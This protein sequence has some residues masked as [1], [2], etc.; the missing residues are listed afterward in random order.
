MP[1]RSSDWNISKAC[2]LVRDMA[3]YTSILTEHRTLRQIRAMIQSCGDACSVL[4]AGGRRRSKQRLYGLTGILEDFFQRK[5]W[6]NVSMP[7]TT[8][9]PIRMLRSHL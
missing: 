5:Y 3:G 6:I 4:A 2:C 1:I 8:A 9:K 7:P